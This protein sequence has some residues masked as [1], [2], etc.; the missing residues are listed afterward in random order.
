MDERLQMNVQ[1]R[2]VGEAR[3]EVGTDHG[4]GIMAA[5]MGSG[6]KPPAKKSRSAK[7]SKPK[8][9]LSKRTNYGKSAGATEHTRSTRHKFPQYAGFSA[10]NS[11]ISHQPAILATAVLVAD[12]TAKF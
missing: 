4:A 2:N 11:N 1:L 5:V 12:A 10:A 9:T 8:R 6:G 7:H 3:Q